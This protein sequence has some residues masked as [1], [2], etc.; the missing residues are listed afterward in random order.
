[1]DLLALRFRRAAAVVAVASVSATA[2]SGSVVGGWLPA[3]LLL[4]ALAAAAAV[5]WARRPGG[6][7]RWAPL[8]IVLL[9]GAAAAWTTRG[10]LMELRSDGSGATARMWVASPVVRWI[11]NRSRPYAE[12][13][14][15]DPAL[16]LVQSGRGARTLPAGGDDLAAFARRFSAH[17]GAVV[18]T[19][20]D[21][22]DARARTL[23]TLLGLRE[24]VRAGEGRVLVPTDSLR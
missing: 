7:A 11:D 5:R 9:W 16:V 24:V 12:I 20:P 10:R 21:D 3:A 18:L 14:A 23:T 13:Y 17:P 6:P 19:R 15:T 2:W 8:A 1:M 22:D 4:L